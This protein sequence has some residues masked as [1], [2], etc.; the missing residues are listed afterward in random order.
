MHALRN[1]CWYGFLWIFVDTQSQV[2]SIVAIASN[3]VLC[4]CAVVIEKGQFVL[5]SDS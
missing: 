2:S 3:E 4:A 1:L 5:F